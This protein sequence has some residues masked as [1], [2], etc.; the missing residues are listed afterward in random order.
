MTAEPRID[1]R[2]PTERNDA[3]AFSPDGRL[4]V[5]GGVEAHLWEAATGRLLATLAGHEREAASVAFFPDGRTVAT[6]D[7]RSIHLWDA[8]TGDPV[9]T[10]VAH[11]GW[12]YCA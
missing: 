7:F 11:T 12:V 8:A 2:P 5:T 3:I 9:N 1:I 10:N 6:S 4:L